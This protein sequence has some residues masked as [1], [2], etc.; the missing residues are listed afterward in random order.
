MMH[1]NEKQIALDFDGVICDSVQ[2]MALSGWRAWRC[3]I[4]ATAPIRP[5]PN[6]ISRFSKLRPVINVGYQSI[7]LTQ[8]IQEGYVE[9]VVYRDFD[10]ICESIMERRQLCREELIVEFDRARDQWIASDPVDWF[11][12]HTFYPGVVEKIDR[13]IRGQRPIFIVTTKEKRFAIRLLD[14]L[15]LAISSEDIFGLQEGKKTDI[16]FR[17][18]QERS[19]KKLPFEFVDDRLATLE[20]ICDDHRLQ[21]L[22]LHLAVWGYNNETQRQS[23]RQNSRINLL[24]LREFIDSL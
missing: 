8:M 1:S 10:Q 20:N 17:L 16:L 18:M 23:A 9:D 24:G 6:F 14:E 11:E 3:R 22:Q 13:L 19:S 21:S 4:D 7:L 2:E 5:T 15:G 12:T